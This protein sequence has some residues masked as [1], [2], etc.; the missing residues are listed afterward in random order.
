[1]A[2]SSL[3]E[4]AQKT[5]CV[6][7]GGGGGGTTRAAGGP[8]GTMNDTNIPFGGHGGN[9]HPAAILADAATAGSDGHPG[10]QPAFKVSVA[11]Q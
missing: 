10:A 3:R 2:W 9:A 4:N 11:L 8:G 5:P 6:P 1:M 7:T